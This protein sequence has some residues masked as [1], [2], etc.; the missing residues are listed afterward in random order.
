MTSRTNHKKSK[1]RTDCKITRMFFSLR[2]VFNRV[3]A[4][5]GHGALFAGIYLSLPVLTATQ[6]IAEV[7]VAWGSNGSGQLGDGT[8]TD[9]TTPVQVSGFTGVTAIAA[10]TEHSLALKSDGTVWAW[11]GNLYGRLGDGTAANRTTPV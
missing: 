1:G 3:H 10:G 11:G 4:L 8:T 7:P 6:A 9:R 2:T 5:L